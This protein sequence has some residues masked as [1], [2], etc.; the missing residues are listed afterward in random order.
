LKYGLHN[1]YLFILKKLL[2]IFSLVFLL[3]SCNSVKRNQKLLAQGDYERAIELAVKKLQKD[4][5]SQNNDAHIAILE[6]AFEKAT[7][8]DTRRIAFLQKQGNSAAAKEIYYTYQNMDYIQDRIRPLLPIY[9]TTLVRNAQFTMVDYSSKIIDA[10]DDYIVY[11]YDEAAIYMNT[12]TPKDYRTAYHIY[13]ELEEMQANYK[14]VTNKKKDARFYGTEFV[15]VALNNSTNQILPYRLEQELLNL[16]TYGL[17]DFWTEYHAQKEQ[18]TEYSYGITLNIRD[19]AISPEK[20]NETEERRTKRIKDGWEYEYDKRGNVAK[21]SLGND[22]KKDKYVSVTA[23][24]TYTAQVKSAF[25]GGDVIYT[26]RI[27]GQTLN[28]FPLSSEFVFENTFARFRG[29]KRAL[30]REDRSFLKY[31]FIPFPSSEQMVYDTGEDL[32]LK[33]KDIISN[34]TL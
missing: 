34:N 29:D 14:D 15:L 22:I 2:S 30:T 24:V 1:Q 17:D 33:L 27:T 23:H 12:Q 16:N 7:S 32:K 3:V 19:I 28:R 9:S 5:N 8:E 21:D 31:D 13:C 10:K 26:D 18:G 25:V 20:I 6:K 11:L 4:K